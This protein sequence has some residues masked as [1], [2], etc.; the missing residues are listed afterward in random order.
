MPSGKKKTVPCQR[1]QGT[2]SYYVKLGKPGQDPR[3]KGGYANIEWNKPTGPHPCNVCNETGQRPYKPP[4]VGSYTIE[5]EPATQ[6][7]G[8]WTQ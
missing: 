6:F 2:G 5:D 8:Q 3:E 1:C 4:I 7:K